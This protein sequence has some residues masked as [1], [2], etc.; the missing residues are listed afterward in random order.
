[1]RQVLEFGGLFT[2]T[3]KK[4]QKLSEDTDDDEISSVIEQVCRDSLLNPNSMNFLSDDMQ[5]NFIKESIRA[6]VKLDKDPEIKD[7]ISPR[8]KDFKIIDIFSLR[9]LSLIVCRGRPAQK[10]SFLTSIANLEL[11]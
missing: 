8:R 11:K 7:K 2:R 9:V 10:A 1:M 5:N 6:S 3:K 4:N